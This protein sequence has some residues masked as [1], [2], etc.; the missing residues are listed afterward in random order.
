MKE[1]IVVSK[2]YKE[3]NGTTILR[4]INLKVVE[5]DSIAVVGSSGSGKSV[6]IK[7]ISGLFTVSSGSIKVNSTEVGKIHVSDR[8]SNIRE[9][10]GMLFQSNAL[11]D[12]MTIGENITF[13]V[14]N[15]M[16]KHGY[17]STNQRVELNKL[18]M[19]QLEIVGLARNNLEKYPYE[20]SGGMQKRVAIA[21]L[22]STKPE[23]ILLDEPTTGLDPVTTGNISRLMVDIKNHINATML[24]ITHDPICV[25]ELAENIVLIENKTIGWSGKIKDLQLV[26]N[27][28]LNSF[29]RHCN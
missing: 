24:T 5:G 10:M 21:R 14:Y 17:I 2:L 4:D 25:S 19:E 9:K 16:S 11:F 26:D 3:F 7:C 18:A 13:G 1:K 8:P 22:I 15:T 12:S 28:Y 29:K 20:L 6:L 23:I 27:L